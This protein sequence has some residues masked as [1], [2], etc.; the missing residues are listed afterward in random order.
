MRDRRD[1]QR[2]GRRVCEEGVQRH[3]GR[4]RLAASRPVGGQFGKCAEASFDVDCA[5]TYLIYSC[6]Y[7]FLSIL[8]GYSGHVRGF[9]R[10]CV[11]GGAD[12]HQDVHGVRVEKMCIGEVTEEDLLRKL[13]EHEEHGH[14]KDSG[15]LVLSWK[16]ATGVC[17]GAT[18]RNVNLENLDREVPRI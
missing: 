17:F 10:F 5:H 18:E 14:E 3:A 4:G 2:G 12:D 15:G 6:V 16:R 9:S 11:R 13:F 7:I 8:F 1:R